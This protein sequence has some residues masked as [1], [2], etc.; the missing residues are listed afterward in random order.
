M[1]F[2]KILLD[3]NFFK[4][5]YNISSQKNYYKMSIYFNHSVGSGEHPQHI[6]E[7]D[8]SISTMV[9]ANDKLELL[10][11]TFSHYEL[12]VAQSNDV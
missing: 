8:K 12:Q 11:K 1:N 9:D 7:M 3:F 4:R 6:E 5:N 10:T 2:T